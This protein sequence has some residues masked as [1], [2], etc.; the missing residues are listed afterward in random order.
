MLIIDG[1][2]G[3]G[4]GQIVRTSLSLAALT[5]R[6][7]EL[8]N[9]RAG[10]SRPGLRPQHLTAVR[11]AAALCAAELSGDAVNSQ[12]LRFTPRAPVVGGRYQ[13]DVDDHAPHGSAGAVML[14]WQ[15]LLWPLLFA[16]EPSALTLR[17]GTHVPFSPPF[18]YAAHVALP[19]YARLGVQATLALKTWGWMP[20][21]QGHVE[22]TVQPL[23]GLE[24]ADFE[25]LAPLRIDGVA[26]A[27]N[28]PSHIPQRMAQRAAALCRELGFVESAIRP[29]RERAPA[30]GA[31]IFLWLPQAGFSALGRKGLPSEQ[32]AEE[33]VNACRDFLDQQAAV[34]EHL[35]DQLLIPLALAHGVSTFTTHRLTL[36][37][38]TNADLL[39]RWLSVPIT[40]EGVR[41]QPARITV[42][43][44]GRTAVAGRATARQA[45]Q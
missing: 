29:S 10:R 26:A 32:V 38:L 15:T 36:H 43:G 24:A 20:Q 25:P 42:Q 30:T 1:S 31:G 13:F 18:H 2:E 44:C 23:R 21:G 35:A 3:E 28:L 17:G 12:L 37:T 7:F 19:A 33:A 5:G 41:D 9:I 6:P 16:A 34:D 11:A 8:R 14:V 4:G 45:A 40:I 39:R 22:A 27:T